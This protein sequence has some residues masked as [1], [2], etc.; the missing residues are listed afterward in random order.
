MFMELI[1]KYILPNHFS[2]SSVMFSS[3]H[4]EDYISSP[5]LPLL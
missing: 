5:Q 4:I 1:L 3:A 2:P